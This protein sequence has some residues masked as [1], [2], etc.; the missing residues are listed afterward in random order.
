MFI[1]AKCHNNKKNAD[2]ILKKLMSLS[3][4]VDIAILMIKQHGQFVGTKRHS[5]FI[6]IIKKLGSRI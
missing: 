4:E 6:K 3:F 5:I 2:W 1:K